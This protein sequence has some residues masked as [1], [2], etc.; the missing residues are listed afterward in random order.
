MSA[1]VKTERQFMVLDVPHVSEKASRVQATNNQFVFKVDSTATKPEIKAAV[2]LMFKV[3]VV[4]VRVANSLG[5]SKRFGRF[6]GKRG[7][8]KRAFVSI[9]SG[10]EINYTGE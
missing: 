3:E 4:G 5:K 9:K 10:Q 2:E 7:D 6:M 8:V 1:A